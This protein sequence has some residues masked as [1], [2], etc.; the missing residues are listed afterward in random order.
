MA[1]ASTRLLA[2]I[3]PDGLATA[4]PPPYSQIPGSVHSLE[5][6][7]GLPDTSD[8]EDYFGDGDEE[9]FMADVEEME[10]LLYSKDTG[11]EPAAGDEQGGMEE[12]TVIAGFASKLDKGKKRDLDEDGGDPQAGP[13]AMKRRGRPPKRDSDGNLVP[14]KVKGGPKG[15]PRTR[16]ETP[17]APSRPIGRPKFSQQQVEAAAARKVEQEAAAKIENDKMEL[18][19]EARRVIARAKAAKQA[20][21]WHAVRSLVT[22]T[23][24]PRIAGWVNSN[25]YKQSEESFN[26][27]PL[28]KD[29]LDRYSMVSHTRQPLSTY[30]HDFLASRQ[31]TKF[32]LLHIHIDTERLLYKDLMVDQDIERRHGIPHTNAITRLFNMAANG[33]DIFYKVRWSCI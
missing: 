18:E 11:I 3:I 28:Q 2:A 32:T 20:Q 27:L 9:S 13:V 29:D 7:V 31:Q 16:L 30:R 26:I 5:D 15:R 23:S 1:D 10:S 4:D 25:Q 21:A 14:P 19:A 22:D 17:V 24:L 33:E 6:H 8:K 12:R